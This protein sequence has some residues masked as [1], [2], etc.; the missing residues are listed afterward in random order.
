[1]A[2]TQD[3][4]GNA[5]RGLVSAI[6]V[7][8]VSFCPQLSAD[9][10]LV[11]ASWNMEHLAAADGAGCRARLEADYTAL[12]AVAR[13]LDA[14]IIA[15]QEV[16]NAAAVG[17]VFDASRYD[18][19]VSPRPEARLGD[20]R[21]TRGQTRTAQRTA[22]AINRARLARLGLGWREL[23]PFEKIGVDARRWGTRIWV[24]PL[25]PVGESEEGLE[26]MSLHLKSG[27]AWG[28]LDTRDQRRAACRT[29]RRQRG[30][31]EQWIDARATADTPFVLMGDFNRQLDQPNDDFWR[32]IDDG[33][34]CNWRADQGFGRVCLPGSH[35]DDADADLV[36]ANAGVPFVHARNPK[37]PYAVDHFVLGGA[38]SGWLI[39]G[40]YDALG[41]DSGVLLSD[42]H[43]IRI[44][45]RLLE[46]SAVQ[47]R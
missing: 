36:L 13:R 37:Y 11:L 20:C 33:E 19:V 18:I 26:L 28:R 40:S 39:D 38:A 6:A 24:A 42:H 5:F 32:D 25:S 8:W 23:P 43:P 17:R 30:I 34:V 14:D 27:C 3:F 21:G 10:G 35:T 4:H 12:R 45:L 9:T 22:F 47:G 16:E 1:M 41:Y 44:R 29:L 15:L 46:E 2:N 7:L 31:L